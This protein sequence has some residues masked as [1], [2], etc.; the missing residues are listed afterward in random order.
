MRIV[1]ELLNGP[2]KGRKI[3][4][5]ANQTITVGRTE[6]SDFVIPNDEL[7]SG[8]HFALEADR[9]TCVI[10]DLGSANGTCVNGAPSNLAALNN[11]DRI[12]AGESH[13]LVSIDGG[14][15]HSSLSP[16]TAFEAPIAEAA[17]QHTAVPRQPAAP[18]T[19]AEVTV[20]TARSEL[21]HARGLIAQLPPLDLAEHLMRTNPLHLIVD[22][23]RLGQPRPEGLVVSPLFDWIPEASPDPGP[24]VI[25]PC[26]LATA[27]PLLG[28]GQ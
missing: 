17:L 18:P 19:S 11:G 26:D 27:A 1:L 21:Y 10:R 22:F 4:L 15:A 12:I 9:E 14:L 6:W 13:F 16:T 5:A 24:V 3:R 2:H 8:K 25:S 20:Q 23:G 28:A 7:L